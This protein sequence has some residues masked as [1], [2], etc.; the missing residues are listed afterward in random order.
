MSITPD[1]S[2][3][4]HAEFSRLKPARVRRLYYAGNKIACLFP[5]ILEQFQFET[6]R[7]SNHTACSLAEKRGFSANF[8]PV[9]AMVF[10]FFKDETLYIPNSAN[11][12]LSAMG[13]AYFVT[14][15][16]ILIVFR[17]NGCF[18]IAG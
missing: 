2:K 17:S 13:R 3:T 8:W 6:L 11:I 4:I 1:Q 14:A 12:A 7:V 16:L 5:P 10:T 15:S 18:H 9:G